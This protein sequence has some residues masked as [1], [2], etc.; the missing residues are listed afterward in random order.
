[1]NLFFI[2]IIASVIYYYY[3]SNNQTPDTINETKIV[4]NMASQLSKKFIQ[5]PT[6][7]PTY[8]FSHGGPTFM[9]E[10]DDFGNKGAWNA[11]KKIGNNIKKNWKPDYIVVVSAHWQS[12]ETI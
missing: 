9:Y 2:P 10:L 3:Y 12:V 5:N 8:F 4:N 7:F 11:V 1:M 6:P